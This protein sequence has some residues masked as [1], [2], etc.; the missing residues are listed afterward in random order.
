MPS[1]DLEITVSTLAY[2]GDAVG[3]LADGR[4]VFVPFALPGEK[5]RIELV[6]QKER[7]ARGRVLEVLEASR[8]R[9][10]PRCKHFTTCGGCHYQHLDYM[11]QL[12]VK[13]EV[14]RDQLIR[15]G[16]FV[17]PPVNAT[18]G[19]PSHWNY[20][21]H[22]QFHPSVGGRLGFVGAQNGSAR[23]QIVPVQ[24]CH[25]PAV[26][27]NA[28]WPQITL[29]ADL[30]IE[31]VAVRSGSED[32]L[33]IVFESSLPDAPDVEIDASVSVAHVF[34]GDALIL[35]GEDHLR[36]QVLGRSF[37]VS[38]TTFFQ[39]NP[40]VAEKMV[41]YL[42]AILPKPCGTVIDAYCGAGLFSA[43][44]A[45]HCTRLIGIEAG[46]PACEDFAANL[47]E[48]ENVEL[49]EDTA[50]HVL[51]ALRLDPDFALVDPPR[52]GVG[53][54]ALDAL[55]RLRPP[56]VA[57]VSCDPA[58]LARDA[59]LLVEAGYR[60][61]SVTPFDMFPQTYHI[62]SIGVFMR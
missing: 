3:R 56:L 19:S 4:A 8:D 36:M 40:A 12:T 21:N 48:F 33:M 58:T 29:D 35:A 57:Y 54:A 50:E 55:I 18:I 51:A 34:S 20:R 39:V 10:P 2:G 27:I 17:D 11:D 6:E 14:L 24:E 44:M 30:G 31:R 46:A 37:R 59:R 1:G 9:I 38:P 23:S 7:F 16:R 47:D 13:A 52:A 5:L 45:P 32:D 26:S 28:L 53:R 22:V 60:L 15:I 61:E 49:Y 43:F 42:V 62:E 25:L 41:E